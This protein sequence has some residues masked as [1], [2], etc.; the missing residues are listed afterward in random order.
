[1]LKVM[2]GLYF[3]KAAD[4]D[5]PLQREAWSEPG[6]ILIMHGIWGQRLEKRM[7]PGDHRMNGPLP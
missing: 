7:T 2:S 3:L 6:R 5:L 4:S 1:M